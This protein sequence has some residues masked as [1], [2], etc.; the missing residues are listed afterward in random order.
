VVGQGNAEWE[1]FKGD[2]AM[3]AKLAV[4]DALLKMQVELMQLPPAPASTPLSAK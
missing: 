3:S 2:F 4:E 1:Q